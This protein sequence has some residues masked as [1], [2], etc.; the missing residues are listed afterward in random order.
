M[1]N[2]ILLVGNIIGGIL[3][4]IYFSMFLLSTK[5]IKDKR[6]LFILCMIF[7]GL[8]LIFVCHMNY[9][10]NF[11]L[12]YTLMTYIMLKLFYKD[13]A[14]ITDIVTFVISIITLGVISVLISIT[15]GMNLIGLLLSNIIPL[16]LAFIFRHKLTKIDVFYTK[17]WN[18]HNDRKM[19]KSI[20]IR[21]ISTVMTIITFL[22]L[23]LWLI[24][25]IF[26]VRR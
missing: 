22:L 3:Q 24:Y 23:H 9:N 16:L 14:R 21:G 4:P 13:K 1:N 17:F 19:L 18:R 15:I 7:E 12:T 11:E 20:T 2:E 5:N 10:I 8:F 25:G 26:I 6:F